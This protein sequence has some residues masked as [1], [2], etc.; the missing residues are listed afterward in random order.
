MRKRL[1]SR[2]FLPLLPRPGRGHAGAPV[3][4][5]I[6]GAPVPATILGATRT[7]TMIGVS[8]ERAE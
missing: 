3:P 2:G 1:G 4:A 7:A 6:L 8:S 5:T